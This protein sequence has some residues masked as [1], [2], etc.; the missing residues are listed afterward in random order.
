MFT[1][2][3]WNT[4]VNS[5]CGF[6]LGNWENI[7]NFNSCVWYCW[8]TIEFRKHLKTHTGEKSNQCSI[9]EKRQRNDTRVASHF[10]P[11]V[12]C[13][14]L[15]SL[16]SDSICTR[17]GQLA[18]RKYFPMR[19]GPYWCILAIFANICANFWI[20]RIRMAIPNLHTSLICNCLW[21]LQKYDWYWI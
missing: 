10:F 19:I 3:W 5:L 12:W 1:L 18:M 2:Q 13:F 17:D 6:L 21:Y 8:G 20:S 16:Q 4:F 7:L 9:V 11:R 15:R 14:Q